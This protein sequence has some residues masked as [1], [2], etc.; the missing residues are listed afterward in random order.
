MSVYDASGLF[1]LST[2]THTHTNTHTHTHTHYT[3][4]RGDGARCN[5]VRTRKHAGLVCPE[6]GDDSKREGLNI[7]VW[8]GFDKRILYSTVC[9][10]HNHNI[11]EVLDSS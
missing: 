4:S 6:R 2:H 9:P 3:A 11:K 10:V 5:R 8:C 1:Y 7:C